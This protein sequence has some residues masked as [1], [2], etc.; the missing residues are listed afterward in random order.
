MKEQKMMQDLNEMLK[1][2]V[3]KA[4]AMDWRELDRQINALDGEYRMMLSEDG[5]SKP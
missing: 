3:E 2:L 4:P 1:G 5:E